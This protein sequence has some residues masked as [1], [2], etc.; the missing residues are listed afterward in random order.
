MNI[1]TCNEKVDQISRISFRN[2]P[3]V[4]YQV[5]SI[6]KVIAII[7]DE[8]Q[9]SLSIIKNLDLIISF[10]CI[11]DNINVNCNILKYNI[12]DD[13]RI[14]IHLEAPIIE[15]SYKLHLRA[16][17]K[18]SNIDIDIKSTSI[19]LPLESS[20][21]QV[22]KK[23]IKMEKHTEIEIEMKQEKN[24]SNLKT[25]FTKMDI[26]VPTLD[27]FRTLPIPSTP[28]TTVTTSS[29]DDKRDI[30]RVKE[31]YGM[32]MGSQVWDSCIVL[33]RAIYFNESNEDIER[34]DIKDSVCIDLGAGTG[35]LGLWI[36]HTFHYKTTVLTDKYQVLTRLLDENIKLNC[37]DCTSGDKDHQQPVSC[38]HDTGLVVQAFD[39]ADSYHLE[40]MIATYDTGINTILAS[41]VLYDVEASKN[42]FQVLEKLTTPSTVVY[43]AQKLRNGPDAAPASDVTML[44]E[45]HDMQPPHILRE[46][47]GCIVYKITK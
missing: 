6:I 18:T 31:S 22:I 41:D 28:Y 40:R 11:K 37:F 34:R 44:C 47:A 43:L 46:E 42:L 3:K 33:A 5:D 7:A 26:N 4:L 30:I 1:F 19:V 25:C 20:I 12:T 8:F 29:S 21:F 23:E 17:S 10:Y 24:K 39:W 15:G 13:Y 16:D 27:V 35:L 14:I 9:N 32:S 2:A 38:K 45:K 36:H